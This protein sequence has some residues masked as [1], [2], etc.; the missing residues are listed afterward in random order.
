MAVTQRLGSTN[1]TELDAAVARLEEL[2]ELFRH[3]PVA[4]CVVDRDVRYVRANENYA[5]VVGYTLDELIGLTMNEVIP[6]SAQPGALAGAAQVIETGEPLLNLELRRVIPHQPER[7]R[8]WMVNIHPVRRDGEVTGAVAVLQDITEIRDAEEMARQRLAELESVYRN[9]PVGLSFIDPDLRYLRVNQAI[10]DM[11]GVSIEEMVGRSYRDLSPE[12]ADAAEPYLRKLIERGESIRNLEVQA[13]PPVDPDSVHD[14]LLS[15]DPVHSADGAIAGYTTSVQDVTV[16]RHTERT[17]A[18]RLDELETLYANTPVGLCHV[19]A[20]LRIVNMNPLFAQLSERPL[21]DQIDALFEEVLPENISARLVPQMRSVAR[22]G[23][24]LLPIEIRTL[25]AGVGARE[26]TW[27]A[28]AHPVLS[29]TGDV[30]DIII[31]LQDVTL[32][33]E[34]Q[35]EIEQMRDRLAEAQLVSNL[36]SWEWDLIED[37][38]WWSPALYKVFGEDLTYEPSY[39]GVYEHVHPDDKA[40][41]REQ[42][43]RALEDD[44]PLRATYRIIRPDGQE[45]LLFG[46]ARLERTE[47]GQPKRFI[48]TC[49]DV[50]EFDSSLSKRKQRRAKQE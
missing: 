41:F 42:L 9:A 15:M 31:V 28:Q 14:Y 5:Q 18:R 8:I 19:D 47:A 1:S 16:M 38:V 34:R 45:R 50:T 7:D 4:L 2:E 33:A 44:A 25:P 40:N 11:N 6:A 22:V 26:Y 12:S 23:A 36:G 21:R 32:L 13:T 49:Q 17:S 48:G 43:D 20:N 3:T 46:A 27:L 39:D 30:T 35:R 24:S 29:A 37:K 10:A